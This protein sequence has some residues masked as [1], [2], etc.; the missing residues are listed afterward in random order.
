MTALAVV[1]VV[2][3]LAAFVVGMR[4]ENTYLRAVVRRSH[5]RPVRGGAVAFALQLFAAA[6]DIIVGSAAH[7]TG[8]RAIALAI[9]APVLVVH[10][11]LVLVAMPNGPVLPYLFNRRDLTKAG[12]SGSTARA[13]AWAGG[14]GALLFGFITILGTW[15]LATSAGSR[16]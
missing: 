14:A 9:A 4:F 10:G 5:D 7:A 15:I 8:S 16:R 6:V 13:I 11:A 1:G 12:A 2:C 3:V